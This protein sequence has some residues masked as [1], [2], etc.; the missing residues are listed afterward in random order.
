[1]TAKDTTV[2]NECDFRTTC[3]LFFSSFFLLP[4]FDSLAGLAWHPLLSILT[5]CFADCGKPEPVNVSLGLIRVDRCA[6]FL[7]SRRKLRRVVFQI[8]LVEFLI[9][10]AVVN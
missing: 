4:S 8:V 1:M 5:P 3:T 9:H 6:A 7:V 2:M 10:A